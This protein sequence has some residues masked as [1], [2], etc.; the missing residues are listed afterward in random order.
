MLFLPAGLLS[1]CDDMF[2]VLLEM[3]KDHDRQVPSLTSSWELSRTV[4]DRFSRACSVSTI[5]LGVTTTIRFGCGSKHV[6]T[7]TAPA[8]RARDA[9]G[10]PNML[11]KTDAPN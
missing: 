10:A 8:L 7:L 5:V 3:P 6:K 2:R 9:Q 1:V 4:Q 11:R